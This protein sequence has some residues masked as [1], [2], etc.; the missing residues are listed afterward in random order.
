[1]GTFTSNSKL[2]KLNLIALSNTGIYTDLS[3]LLKNSLDRKLI[4]FT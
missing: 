3:L 4:F 1:M 2:S